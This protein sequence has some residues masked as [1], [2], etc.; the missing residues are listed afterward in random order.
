[1]HRHV[2]TDTQ[3]NTLTHTLTQTH[4]HIHA[5]SQQAARFPA[6][7]AKDETQSLRVCSLSDHSCSALTLPEVCPSHI[8]TLS[9]IRTHIH[10]QDDKIVT[11]ATVTQRI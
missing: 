11:E 5:V 2:I 4:T 8:H 1:M 7:Q 6:E 3:M 9:H 10:Y